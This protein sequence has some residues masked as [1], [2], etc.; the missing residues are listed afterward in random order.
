MGFNR[1]RIFKFAKGFRGRSKNV[2]SIARLRVYKALQHATRNR[3]QK[4]RDMS[5]LWI[6]RINAGSREHGV[7]MHPAVSLLAPPC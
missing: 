6:T 2:I 7:S 1:A 3:H 4:K 5:A